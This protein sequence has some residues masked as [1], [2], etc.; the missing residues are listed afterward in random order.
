MKSLFKNNFAAI[1]H[2]GSTAIINMPAKPTIDILL[3]VK[4]IDSVDSLNKQLESHGYEAWGAYHVAN[5]R[6]FV[7]GCQKRTHHLMV[8]ERH[9]PK[10]KEYIALR[11]YLIK[12]PQRAKD[13]ANLKI[14]LA[15]QYQNNRRAYLTGKQQLVET[16][17]KEALSFFKQ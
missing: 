11:D 10:I 16:L 6:F 15:E 14:K 7:K 5:S 4:T 17:K 3:E 9:H 8:F 1:H 2:I 12:Q 13:Y